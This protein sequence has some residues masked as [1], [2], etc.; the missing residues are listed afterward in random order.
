[1]YN[2]FFSDIYD[3]LKD[4]TPYLSNTCNTTHFFFLLIIMKDPISIILAGFTPI[5]CMGLEYI[6]QNNPDYQICQCF[7]SKDEVENFIVNGGNADI[8]IFA[9]RLTDITFIPKT[10]KMKILVFTS[11]PERFKYDNWFY[12]GISG[13]IDWNTTNE[14][15]CKILS[16]LKSGE[17]GLVQEYF[18]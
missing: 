9:D 6:I 1:M 3:N 18:K 8:L 5:F 16:N 12:V 15:F 10:L 17:A 2:R 11:F 13:T 4:R 14:D 7:S